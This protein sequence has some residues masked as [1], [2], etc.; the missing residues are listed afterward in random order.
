MNRYL[1]PTLLA[2]ALVSCEV[3]SS[4]PAEEPALA[5]GAPHLGG[6]TA[7]LQDT[8]RTVTRRIIADADYEYDISPDGRLTVQT[9][10]G[11]TGDLALRDL[12]T[13]EVR[14][15]THNTAPY[16]PGEAEG[17]RFSR[18]GEWVAYTWY[19]EAQPAFYKLGVV[20]I[21][22]TDPRLIY[23]DRA[24]TW[25]QAEDWSPDGHQLLAYRTVAGNDVGELLLISTEDGTSR[26]LKLFSG[27]ETFGSGGSCFSPD[28]RYVAY[29]SAQVNP[30]DN[31]I[32]V[33][34]VASGEKH[35]LVE[36]P[37]NDE[38]LGWAPG[39]D[40]IL[41]RSD[42]SGT[43][44]A[45]LLPVTDGREDGDP[46]LV[47]PDM[48][49]TSGVGFSPDGRYFYKVSTQR[50]QVYVIGFDP[51]TRSVIGSPT[52]LAASSTGNSGM[53]IWSPDGRHL[54]Y[55]ADGGP[56]S[57][58]L[59]VVVRSMET[60]DEKHFEL[61]E[62]SQ[63]G[64]TGWT[65]DGRSI[66]AGVAGYGG[67]PD[68]VYRID[69]QTGRKEVLTDPRRSH[70]LVYPRA[71]LRNEPLVYLVSEEN[72]D[73]QAAFHI[74]RYDAETHDSTVLFRT[75]Y[76]EWGQILG[77]ALSPDGQTLAFGYSPVEGSEPQSLILLPVNGDE[78]R[79]LPV[80]GAMG[81]SWS[82][83]GEFLLFHRFAAVG[84]VWESWLL[85]LADGEPQPIGL[86]TKSP[87]WKRF[88]VHPNGQSIT[89]TSTTGGTE[90]WVMENFLPRTGWP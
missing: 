74:L 52:A 29:H 48:W 13:G 36:S 14:H 10:W 30:D 88:D 49:Q 72:A 17:A 60:G 34:D 55:V 15:L 89:Y 77:P 65:A 23:Q 70:P 27:S 63:I 82:A 8:A 83:D 22:G 90:L 31:D 41:F 84:P 38:L 73:G 12:D 45:W 85:D 51:E 59:R 1:R 42:R 79:E 21:E 44:G 54:L 2:F 35:S 57:S 9:D 7:L 43:P 39:G 28:G 71:A 11:T 37:A 4:T 67:N 32:F 19:D 47:K 25:I 75:P 40:H 78:P 18:D 6:A 24:T 33:I 64:V 62:S 46:W 3:A 80:E 69:V 56:A 5:A 50:R 68:T 66:I 53:G 61:A 16:D 81:I 58:S 76:G 87:G 86:T 26:L 20:D